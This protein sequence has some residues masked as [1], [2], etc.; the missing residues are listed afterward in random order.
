VTKNSASLSWRKK[1]HLEYLSISFSLFFTIYLQFA[2]NLGFT[3]ENECV[4]L[5]KKRKKEK[6]N[7]TAKK[8]IVVFYK[9]SLDSFPK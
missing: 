7:T 9:K 2:Q 1:E 4:P 8:A 3:V 6:Q 5:I